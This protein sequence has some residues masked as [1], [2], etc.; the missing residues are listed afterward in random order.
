MEQGKRNMQL[1][2]ID[3]RNNIEFVDS[4]FNVA[5]SIGH[6]HKLMKEI[7]KEKI[8]PDTV[9]AACNC[10]AKINETINTTVSAAKFLRDQ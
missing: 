6:M 10:V 3:N 9:N 4:K 5:E 2:Q 1:Q 7:T 8:T